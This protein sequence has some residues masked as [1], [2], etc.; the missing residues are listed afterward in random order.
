M[1]KRVKRLLGGSP[2]EFDESEYLERDFTTMDESEF[3]EY[4]IRENVENTNLT[5]EEL[6]EKP[7]W[8]IEE[9]IGVDF[10]NIFMPRGNRGGYNLSDRKDVV[11]PEE[12][13]KRRKKVDMELGLD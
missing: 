8:E 7:L 4:I 2:R 13:Q 10:S 9:R 12:K 5:E 1:F 6:R 3:W 11:T